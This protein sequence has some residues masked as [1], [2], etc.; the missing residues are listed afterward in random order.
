MKKTKHI[1][2]F[3]ITLLDVKPKVWRRIQVPEEYNFWGLHVA[4]Q[5]AMGWTDSHLHQFRVMNPKDGTESYLGIPNGEEFFGDLPTTIAGWKKD[6]RDYFSIKDNAC[7]YYEYD[8]GDGWMHEVKL[9]KILPA[10]PGCKYPIC[11]AGK[12]ACPPEDCGG[13]YGYKGFLKIIN[14]PRHEE[15]QSML[16]WVDGE[17][18]PKKFEPQKVYFDNPS[19]R[20][21]IVFGS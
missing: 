3:K 8:F 17:F 19:R 12:N 20:W 14:N 13:V 15:H 1:Y 21:K 7:G 18:D 4:I 9:E 6:I 2:E 5:N 16:E 10:I 11:T